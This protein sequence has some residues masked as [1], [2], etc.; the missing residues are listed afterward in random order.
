M[1]YLSLEECY[2]ENA[3]RH[4]LNAVRHVVN[5]YPDYARGS[6]RKA[7]KWRAKKAFFYVLEGLMQ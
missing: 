2:E 7:S 5:G 4:E 3:R 6:L 1:R